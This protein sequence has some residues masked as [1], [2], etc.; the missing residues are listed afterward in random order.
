MR[1]R[2]QFLE[3]VEHVFEKIRDPD[4]GY[5]YYYNRRTGESSWTKPKSLGTRDIS[6][7]QG[8]GGGSRR[9]RRNG[10]QERLLLSTIRLAAGA[11]CCLLQCC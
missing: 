8:R 6:E 9:A 10:R 4:S 5:Y 2:K 7:V 1:A 11:S 3:L